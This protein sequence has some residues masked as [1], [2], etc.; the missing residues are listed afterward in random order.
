MKTMEFSRIEMHLTDSGGIQLEV[1]SPMQGV[2]IFLELSPD[3]LMIFLV[4]CTNK[5]QG[6][7]EIV[8]ANKAQRD[9]ER[10]LRRVKDDTSAYKD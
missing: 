7:R 2:P 5:L 10:E 8:I 9:L 4:E 3:E 1:Y 6:A